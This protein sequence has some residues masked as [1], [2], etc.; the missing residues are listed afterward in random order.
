MVECAL[1]CKLK[2]VLSAVYYICAEEQ[3]ANG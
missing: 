2:A 1:A 3:N